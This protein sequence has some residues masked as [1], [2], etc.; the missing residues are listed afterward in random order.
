MSNVLVYDVD[1]VRREA[2]CHVL[3]TLQHNVWWL[4]NNRVSDPPD[5]FDLILLHTSD[6]EMFQE[7]EKSL[8]QSPI[9]RYSGAGRYGKLDGVPR[10]VTPEDPLLLAELGSF[11]TL[12]FEGK[13]TIEEAVEQVW[14]PRVPRH[15]IA[16]YLCRLTQTPS[17]AGWKAAFDEEVVYWRKRNVTEAANWEDSDAAVLRTFLLA[18]RVLT[19]SA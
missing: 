6:E 13:K 4:A 19:S 1:P 18:T 14:Q 8:T 10:K 2:H 15:V 12:V 5:R 11:T 7:K 9:L 3:K 16:H 17:D